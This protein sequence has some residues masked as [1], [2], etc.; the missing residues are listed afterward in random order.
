VVSLDILLQTA[1]KLLVLTGCIDDEEFHV[2]LKQ[3]DGV[4]YL[5]LICQTACLVRRCMFH[6][7]G[8]AAK[9]FRMF[10]LFPFMK[11]TFSGWLK[12]FSSYTSRLF[13]TVIRKMTE[14]LAVATLN[15]QS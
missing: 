14:L 13:C 2:M 4:L 7:A 15:L 10:L 6:S 8:A 12:S 9:R 11:G 3:K 1:S 5:V